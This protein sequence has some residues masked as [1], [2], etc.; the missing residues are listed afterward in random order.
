MK[1]H[2]SRVGVSGFA[3]PLIDEGKET[4]SFLLFDSR[5]S[6]AQGQEPHLDR[7]IFVTL[8][9]PQT[10]PL[11]HAIDCYGVLRVQPCVIQG[12]LQALYRMESAVVR[13]QDRLSER[14]DDS[15]VDE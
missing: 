13:P 15:S 5:E 7:W 10:I 4:R 1:L 6:M 12:Q 9:E 11:E 2:Y 3:I 8:Q 14:E